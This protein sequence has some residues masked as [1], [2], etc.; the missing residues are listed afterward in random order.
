MGCK[1]CLLPVSEERVKQS[2]CALRGGR[3][4]PVS[5]VHGS[6]AQRVTRNSLH[7]VYINPL[8]T[9]VLPQALS[10]ADSAGASVIKL[11][12]TEWKYE[13]SNPFPCRASLVLV[14]AL[15]H[16]ISAPTC[17]DIRVLS[18]LLKHTSCFLPNASTGIFRL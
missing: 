3:V 16:Y 7:T 11:L 12:V 2:S 5:K 6:R 9:S 18:F 17:P 4:S 15:H 1:R 14:T 13:P 8:K 10:F